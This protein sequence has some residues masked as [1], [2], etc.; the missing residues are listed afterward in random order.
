MFALPDEDAAEAVA[1]SATHRISAIQLGAAQACVNTAGLN[2]LCDLD[3]LATFHGTPAG[4][5]QFAQDW[6]EVKALQLLGVPPATHPRVLMRCL[7]TG[8]RKNV[9]GWIREDPEMTLD[10]VLDRLRSDF[11]IAGADGD[12]HHRESLT[13]EAAGGKLR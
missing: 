10:K 13:L 1:A 9:A 8:L 5:D 2:K 3:P 12:S 6:H 7:P 4:W 11:Q